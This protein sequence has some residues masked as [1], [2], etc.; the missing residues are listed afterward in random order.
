MTAFLNILHFYSLY[1]HMCLNATEL[2][3]Y[4]CYERNLDMAIAVD[5]EHISMRNV[6]LEK[7]YFFESLQN[8]KVRA[9]E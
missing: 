5:I 6:G 1:E 7:T 4:V 9:S 2:C 8:L 3:Y